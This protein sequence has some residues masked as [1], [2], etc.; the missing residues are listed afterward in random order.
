MVV[1]LRYGLARLGSA[2]RFTG[3]K[4]P[5][6]RS[7]LLFFLAFIFLAPWCARADVG[8]VLNDSLDTSIARIT[9]SGHSAVYFSRICSASP[10]KLRL[11]RPDEAGSVMSN[12]TTLGEDQ[13]FEWNIVPLNVY[14]YGLP[15]AEDR[16][17]FSSDKIKRALEERYREEYLSGYC[18]GP[19]CSAS[20]SA[21]WR[22]MVS[23]TSSRSIY[24]F[25][26]RTTVEQDK[27][28]IEKFNSLP[29]HNRFNGFTRNCA[30]FTRHVI[31]TYFPH[32]TH[33]DYINDFGMTS[34]KAIAR[35][36]AHYAHRHPGDDYRVLHFAQIPGTIKRSTDPRDGTEQLFRSKKLLVPMLAVAS[37]E[38]PVIAGSYF[39]T[40]RFNPEREFEEHPSALAS[41]IDYEMKLAKEDRDNALLDGLKDAKDREEE[42]AVGS[43]REW[44]RYREEFDSLVDDA[45][46]DEVITDRGSLGHVFKELDEQGA[47]LIGADNSLWLDLDEDGRPT[48]VGLTP[49]NIAAP[50]SDPQLAYELLLA[51]TERVLSSPPH[52]RESMPQFREDW[53]LLQKVRARLPVTVAQR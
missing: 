38:L 25:V 46:R 47:P 23:A 45:V 27:E 24:I 32:A 22:E 35:S 43:A 53:A 39:L 20:K 26:V 41:G 16:P 44:K 4:G 50:D 30:T 48:R 40:G 6:L 31:N 18:P 19:P 3:E 7:K 13:P 33:P 11:C 49:S 28:L 14:L 21:E 29:N 12:Y 8:V 9:G 37:H 34:P 15:S 51:H 2:G 42:D 10:I 17:V 1:W 52:S 36:F 5:F